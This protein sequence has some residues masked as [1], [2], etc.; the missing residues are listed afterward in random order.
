M[1]E[2]ELGLG[3]S[4]RSGK[5]KVY[6]QSADVRVAFVEARKVRVLRERRF[7]LC[8]RIGCNGARAHQMVPAS[9]RSTSIC[10]K[11][12]QVRHSCVPCTVKTLR[13]GMSPESKAL[14]RAKQSRSP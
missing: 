13:S 2:H 5:L 6:A 10:H 4:R 12:F 7:R 11:C 3:A 9:R 8:C 1:H 14:P